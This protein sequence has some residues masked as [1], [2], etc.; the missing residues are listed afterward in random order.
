MTKMSGRAAVIFGLLLAVPAF[1]QTTPGA[2][3]STKMTAADCTAAWNRLDT[4]KLGSVPQ[5]QA[6]PSITNFKAADANNDGKL[7]QQEFQAACS[8]GLVRSS[9][10]SGSGS[11]TS[12]KAK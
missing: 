10:A 4:A 8:K 6:E 2:P 7:S 11:G 3:P 5:A 9:A 12:D 1:A